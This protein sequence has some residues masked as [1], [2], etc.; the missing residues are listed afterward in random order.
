M[1]TELINIPDEQLAVFPDIQPIKLYPGENVKHLNA[2]E[3]YCRMGGNRNL[4][5]LA[6][7]LE[8]KE[9]KI[10]A[11]STKYA[12][13]ERIKKFD[14]DIGKIMKQ[15]TKDSLIETNKKHLEIIDKAI[16][17]WKDKLDAGE[18][19]LTMVQ[20]IEKLLNIRNKLTGQESITDQQNVQV[21]ISFK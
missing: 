21:N 17:M 19:S 6:K 12:W 14:E 1:T 5:D 18:V 2:F 7:I 15:L 13:Q 8:T 4:R 9:G 20:D 3:V 10:F 16:N 11:W